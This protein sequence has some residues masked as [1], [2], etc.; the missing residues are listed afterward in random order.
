[1]KTTLYTS[2]LCL[3]LLVAAPAT[4]EAAGYIGAGASRASIDDSDFDDD[5]T[6]Y[7]ASLGL[8]FNEFIGIEVGYYDLGHM[9]SGNNAIDNDALTAALLLVA[10]LANSRLYAKLGAARLKSEGVF[11]GQ[12]FDEDETEGFGGVG[13]EFGLGPLGLYLEYMTFDTDLDI[14]VLSAGLRLRF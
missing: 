2:L 10:P 4:V 5:D 13:A 1:M 14:D 9:Q 12:P 8:M 11:F 6:T 3:S 7:N